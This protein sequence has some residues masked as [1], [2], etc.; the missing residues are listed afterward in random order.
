MLRLAADT[1]GTFTDVALADESGAVSIAKALTTPERA[2]TGLSEAFDLLAQQ[3]GTSR[4]RLLADSESFVFGTTRATNAVIEGTAAK[5]AFLTTAGFPDILLLREGGK[6]HPFKQLPYRPPYVPRHRTFEIVERVD[7]EG[8]IYVPLD[9]HSVQHAMEGI[10]A[11]GCD[12]VGVCLLW[13]IVN[14][15]HELRV[16]ELLREYL[17]ELPYT[18]SHQLN[19]IL[20]EYRR[21]SSTVIDASLKPLMQEYFET[22]E[23]DLHLGGFSG[24]LFVANSFG[25]FWRVKEMRT[26]PIYAIGSGPALAP[27]AARTY[28][29]AED[30][31]AVG[32][33]LIVCDTGGTSFDV[34]LVVEQEVQRTSELWLGGKWIGHI[35]GVRAVDVKSIGS[36]GGSVVSVD[37]GGLMRVGPRSAGASPG[38]VCYGRGG[39]E[40]TVTDAALVLGLIKPD[41]FLGG[42]LRLDLDGSRNV[43]ERD[44]AQA[45]NLSVEEAAHAALLIATEN[46][47]GAIRGTTIARGMDPRE[48]LMIAGG[49]AAGL[50]AG[51]VARELGCD[52]V[53]VPK[54]AGALSACGG[55]YSDVVAEFSVNHYIHT[56]A[57]DLEA[58]NSALVTV[59]RQAHDFVTS[60]KEL[61]PRSLEIRYIVEAR[62]PGQVWE[63]EVPLKG[64]SLNCLDDVRALE[65]DFHDVHEQVFSISEPNQFVECLLWKARVEA[66][67]GKPPLLPRQQDASHK[68]AITS[69][70]SPAYFA[71]TG[72]RKT[73]RY[74]GRTLS[75]GMVV[76]GPAVIYEPTTTIV[77]SPGM[78]AITCRTGYR[79]RTRSYSE[80]STAVSEVLA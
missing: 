56:E 78:H 80:Q 59:T 39:T 70:V 32:R 41:E 47:V 42:R 4:R 8:T 76:K 17:P 3:R 6:P 37:A 15:V 27:V 24:Q 52:E 1:G 57:V 49:G 12:A 43:L 16:G 44:I 10:R 74:D 21:A 11:A 30:R 35:T 2:F 34:S 13:S 58:L 33:D 9:E 71:P 51:L 50:N 72:W 66:T 23:Q 65:Q 73:S 63:L 77:V 18:L 14:P 67:L 75:A 20:R 25:G 64:G 79:I 31:W 7:S 46:I 62:Y 48:M 54:N 60:F 45:L 29:G 53:L 19:P 38:P 68:E 22:L 55:L 69:S 40:T 5:T 61:A 26:R 36:G 28:A